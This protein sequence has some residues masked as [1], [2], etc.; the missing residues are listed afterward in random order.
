MGSEQKE[1]AGPEEVPKIQPLRRPFSVTAISVSGIFILAIFY[2]FYF[3]REF[4]LPVTLALI[5]SFLLKPAVRVLERARIPVALGS[6]AVLL[7]LL[8]IV[9]AGVLLLAA[10]ASKWIQ[11]A[12]ETFE[13]VETRVRGMVNSADKITKAARTVEHLAGTED[14]TPKVEVKRPGLMSNVWNQTKSF[15]LL[16]LEVFVL[17]YFFLAA[18][19]IFALKLIQVLPRL[20]DKKKAVE[21]MHEVQNGIS[22]YLVSM[23][24]V[25]L[26]EGTVIGTGLAL[27]GMPNPLLWGV[28]A[29]S[30]N[31]IPY[32]GALVAGSVVT[33]VAVVS[34]D[35]VSRALIAPA[36]Y[37]GVNFADNFI[38]PYVMGRRLVLNPV[39]VFLA[40]MFWGWIWGIPGVLLAVPVTMTVKIICDH[41]PALAPF[42]ELLT[43]ARAEKPEASHGMK[44]EIGQGNA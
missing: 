16:A 38:S 4:F 24:L 6:A 14:E 3:A 18:G 2:T 7:V 27:L 9:S 42:A 10:P 25:N 44:R 33:I 23:T 28:L 12:P 17:V 36:I 30:A 31:Y 41:V 43:A 29:F 39:V 32:L 15:L 40:V 1:S 5:L 21:I 22:Q 11:R 20:E 13:K 19:D 8:L 34:F 37:F 35:S 26:F